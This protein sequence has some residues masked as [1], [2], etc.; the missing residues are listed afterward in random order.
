MQTLGK[1]LNGIV[2][3]HLY[4]PEPTLKFPGIETFLSQY[5]K[6]AKAA[7]VDPLGFYIRPSA[8]RPG[9]SSR[10]RSRQRARSTRE[11]VAALAPRQPRRDHR[12]Q[13]RASTNSASWTQ[14]R[15]LMAQFQGV[16]GNDLD[17]FRQAGKQ[18]IARSAGLQKRRA[19][20]LRQAR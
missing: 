14:R 7:N 6:A 17:Q 8:T 5:E 10:R 15:V 20:A 4:V 19:R 11:K 9:R 3:F 18:V 13:D 1:N 12:R 16:N 2:N